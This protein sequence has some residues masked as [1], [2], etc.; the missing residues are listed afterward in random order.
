MN[1]EALRLINRLGLH[2]HPEG[3][4][5]RETY[6]A[7]ELI[8]AESL[9]GRFKGGARSLATAIY[10]LI[11]DDEFSAL[12]RL[13]SD[14]IWHFHAGGVVVIHVLDSAGNYARHELGQT[15]ENAACFQVTIKA[16]TWFG[17]S[18][19]EPDSYALVGCIVS[20][21]FEFKDFELGK[22]SDL[23]RLYPEHR[24]IIEKLT[25]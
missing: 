17:A 6:R 24:E 1:R 20:P 21:G 19:A 8:A 15:G 13:K 10:F 5:F 12:H 3:G 22:R 23:I 14:E 2:K 25:R 9:P 18:L 11:A 4:Y 7:E 16:G